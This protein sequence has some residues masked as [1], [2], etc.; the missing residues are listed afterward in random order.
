MVL[1]EKT[2]IM[3]MRRIDESWRPFC[4]LQGYV[5]LVLLV[6]W[7]PIGIFGYSGA[8]NEY[9]SYAEGIC[10]LMESGATR[11]ILIAHLDKAED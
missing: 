11:E 10:G 7:D 6:D 8:M 1:D 3:H 9:V 2:W 5:R 4:T